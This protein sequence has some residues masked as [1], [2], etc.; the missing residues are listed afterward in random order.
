M[1]CD[2]V[3]VRSLDTDRTMLCTAKRYSSLKRGTLVQ[4]KSRN[5]ILGEVLASTS[6]NS[7]YDSD[8]ESLDVCMAL[9]KVNK[10]RMAREAEKG[11][12]NAK[13]YSY[14]LPRERKKHLFEKA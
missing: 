4:I 6:Y 9:A 5:K 12:K 1:R 11:N 2:L 8:N 3:V 13:N 14:R 10:T 7:E